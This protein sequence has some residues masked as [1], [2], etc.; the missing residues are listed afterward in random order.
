M[1]HSFTSVKFKYCLKTIHELLP[2]NRYSRFT[3]IYLFARQKDFAS[4]TMN[5]STLNFSFRIQDSRTLWS[6]CEH[7][8]FA[9]VA[10]SYSALRKS[11]KM[12]HRIRSV[13]KT[14]VSVQKALAEINAVQV[15]WKVEW[16]GVQVL[17]TDRIS[18]SKWHSKYCT[19]SRKHSCDSSTSF[20]R[21]LTR[22]RNTE[23]SLAS[24]IS[25]H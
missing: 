8:E 20:T 19:Y 21:V 23:E 25:E 22:K 5:I 15:Q 12:T 18:G 6:L 2:V 16:P 24:Y 14:E 17:T 11:L 4:M 3:L 1:P 9:T 13:N 10:T 7:T